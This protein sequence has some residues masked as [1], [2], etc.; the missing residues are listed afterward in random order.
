MTSKRVERGETHAQH[1]EGEERTYRRDERKARQGRDSMIVVLRQLRH[2][3]RD[4]AAQLDAYIQERAVDP[5]SVYSW[6]IEPG[7]TWYHDERINA[8]CAYIATDD[9]VGF[10]LS[11][12]NYELATQNTDQIRRLRAQAQVKAQEAQATGLAA[13]ILAKLQ[14]S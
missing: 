8:L 6:D 4:I 3:K 1:R 2:R 14:V 13:G 9:W 5:T 11:L 12:N 7:A 10:Q